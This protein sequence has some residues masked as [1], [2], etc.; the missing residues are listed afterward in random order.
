MVYVMSRRP[1]PPDGVAEWEPPNDGH[2][3]LSASTAALVLGIS[4]VRVCQL[5]RADRIPHMRRRE[6]LW[7]R[8]DLL[9][10]YAAARVARRARA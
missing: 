7:F 2:V 1:R 8:R 5:A 3:W 9:E 6:R 10:Q 4:R